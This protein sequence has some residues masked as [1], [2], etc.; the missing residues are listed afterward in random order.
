MSELSTTLDVESPLPSTV[1]RIFE[2]GTTIGP[3]QIEALLGRGGQ[4]AVY[5]VRHCR[6]DLLGALKMLHPSSLLIPRM[7]ERFL[8]EVDLILRLAHPNIVEI[9]DLGTSAEGIPYYVMEVLEGKTLRTLLDEMGHLEVFDVFAILEP[10]CAALEFAHGRGIVHRDVKASNIFITQQMPAQI[11]L[12]DFGIAKLLEPDDN[13]QGLTSV[14]RQV[15]TPS[16]MAPEQIAGGIIDSRTD[17]YALGALLHQMLTGRKPFESPTPAGLA[18]LH[19]EAPP[20]RPSE[21]VPISPAFD[22]IVAR[23]MAKRPSNR[24]PSVAAFVD[25]LRKAVYGSTTLM[26]ASDEQ[27][28]VGLFVDIRPR[29][30]LEMDDNTLDS[31][32]MRALDRIEEQ[33]RRGDFVIALYT[34]NSILGVQLLGNT[35][36][37]TQAKRIAL[38]DVARAL[39]AA[40]SMDD[41]VHINATLHVD[42]VTVCER[43]K[44]NNEIVSGV[45]ART[46]TWAP[47]VS[48]DGVCVT[49]AFVRD[50]DGIGLLPGP[51]GLFVVAAG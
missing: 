10:V 21:R 14:G 43:D 50:L 44:G 6:T 4:G 5:K 28:A 18:Q 13:N 48:I 49:A 7:V 11:K 41:A 23:A 31:A 46:E 38:L 33:M 36:D 34:S 26:T 42:T 45:L 37:R 3:W 2:A 24:Y 32:I 17:V 39:H 15:G 47:T 22:E 20:P 8:R 12:L 16:V 19:L 51:E 35:S 1:E 29:G 30:S 40:F 9:Q 25:S 27:Y